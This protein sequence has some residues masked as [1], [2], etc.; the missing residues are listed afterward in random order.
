MKDETKMHYREY[1]K[2]EGVRLLWHH[3]YYDGPLSGMCDC[4]GFRL[5]FSMA[6]SYLDS[7]EY[8]ASVD[9]H[10][11]PWWRRYICHQPTDEQMRVIVGE[12][13][14]FRVMVG[15]HTDYVY[16]ENG[17]RCVRSSFGYHGG[18]TEETVFAFY[19]HQR[20]NPTPQHVYEPSSPDRIVGWFEL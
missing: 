14:R 10:E 2:L 17:V 7:E 20:E 6:E 15:T 9:V 12:H 16:D 3:D 11:W 18:V 8:E 5:W 4:E 13:D 1:P 19:E